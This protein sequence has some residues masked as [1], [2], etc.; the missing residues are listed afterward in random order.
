MKKGTC[1]A[2]CVIAISLFGSGVS[3]AKLPD[4]RA[5][6]PGTTAP[7]DDVRYWPSVT[8]ASKTGVPVGY[9]DLCVGGNAICK[10]RAGRVAK[11]ATGAVGLDAALKTR[12]DSINTSVN[13]SM[14]YVAERP[15]RDRWSVNASG[16]DCEDF[17]LVKKSKLEAAGFP[18]SALVIA[19]ATT[20]FGVDHAVLIVRTDRGDLVLD[21]LTQSVRPWSRSLYRWRSVQS[22]NDTWTWYRLG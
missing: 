22:P 12:I 15:G 4:A 1:I 10:P 5:A 8:F 17:A 9:Y 13:G 18:S 20:S 3:Q 14:R 7:L 6:L 11:T 21:N 2:V 19:L 16:G